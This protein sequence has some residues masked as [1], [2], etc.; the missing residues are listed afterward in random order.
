MSRERRREPRYPYRLPITLHGGG[1]PQETITEDISYRGMF[2]ITDQ[3]PA[4]RQ[5]IQVKATL[6]GGGGEFHTHAMSVFVL[7]RGNPLGRTPG[8]GLQLYALGG[9]SKASW[10]R[11][12]DEVRE[13]LA[14][15][16]P[17]TQPREFV[18]YRVRLAVK[19]RDVSE[20]HTLYTRDI[21]Q[22]GMFLLTDRGLEADSELK[23]DVVHPVTEEVFSLECIVRRVA[24]G[25]SRGI[26]VEFH[27]L[28]AAGRAAFLE[29]VHSTVPEVELDE[30]E[31]VVE[32]DPK[33]E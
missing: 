5:L 3:P 7:E 13:K 33:L 6:P 32:G 24:S 30:L 28:D 22:G 20:L 26:G 18:R 4:L 14:P 2:A 23:V 12:I 19:P 27:R 17:A 11:F 10:S 15:P 31:M 1:L 29:F 21:S 9:E 16:R 25:A 8:C